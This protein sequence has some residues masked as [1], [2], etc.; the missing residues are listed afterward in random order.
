M[1]LVLIGAH[2][3]AVSARDEER[4]TASAESVEESEEFEVIEQQNGRFALRTV[5]GKFLSA[6]PDGKVDASSTWTREWEQFRLVAAS[7]GRFGLL[8][9]HDAFL[10]AHPDGKLTAD[11][12]WLREWE[13]F[14]VRR[15]STA[16]E[17]SGAASQRF[18]G[19]VLV[20]ELFDYCAAHAAEC[21][22]DALGVVQGV[23]TENP[24]PELK[25]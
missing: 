13:E 2:R 25:R 12:K 15:L 16:D 20:G 8:T 22:D 4:A 7:A 17:L 9:H 23:T 11:S 24:Y 1:T 3:K 10:S 21:T 18:S 14:Y 5:S 6:W 19:A